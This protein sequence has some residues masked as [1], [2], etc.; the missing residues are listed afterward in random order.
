[1]VFYL[2]NLSLAKKLTFLTLVITLVSSIAILVCSY[3]FIGKLNWHNLEDELKAAQSVVEHVYIEPLW[4]FD[5]KQINE[6]SNSFLEDESSA[7]VIYIKVQDSKG[8]I[9]YQKHKD[10]SFIQSNEI[11]ITNDFTKIMSTK[12]KKDNTILGE[13]TLGYSTEK[14]MVKYKT[15]LANIFL[16]SF[17]LIMMTCICVYFF[18]N[19]ILTKPLD[20][21]LEHVELLKN[22]K[23]EVRYYSDLS[24]EMELISSAINLSSVIAEF[25]QSVPA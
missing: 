8:E 18:F 3:Y 14:Q 10:Q 2:K 24:K 23:Y 4:S 15:I 21:I 5:Q 22:E 12:I 16:A 20:K 13:V 25:P 17:F 6:I 7:Q 19:K 1:M 11:P 9:L